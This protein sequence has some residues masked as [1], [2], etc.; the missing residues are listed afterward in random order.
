MRIL[1]ADED[2]YTRGFML[3]LLTKWGYESVVAADGD[4]AWLAL[5]RKNH[6]YL[7]ILNANL[8]C[9]SGVELARKVREAPDA[10]EYHI[11]LLTA[12]PQRQQALKAVASGDA[13]D[14]IAR[15]ADA[16]ELRIRVEMGRRLLDMKTSLRDRTNL[17]ALTGCMTH[18]SVVTELRGELNRS[19]RSGGVVAVI[20][21]DLDLFK[22]V[23]G[24]YGQ[25]AGD[26]VLAEAA[27]RITA[28]ARPYD[29][30]GRYGADEFLVVMPGCPLG[31]AHSRARRLR[32]Q[33][34]DSNTG[35][36]NR[37]VPVT[38]SVGVAA[39]D[40]APD[41]DA[42]SLLRAAEA[43]LATAKAAGG[44]RVQVAQSDDFLTAAPRA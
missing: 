13:Q 40:L 3:D 16:N 21:A 29:S 37:R 4:E 23:N 28:T 24:L 44:N 33:F 14:F 15:P 38:I 11:I 12:P 25:V 8:P 31:S 27:K 36:T 35:T 19:K 34:D 42:E 5:N 7:A 17:D 32:K 2:P 22:H 20:L 41:A 6:P 9:T 10:D 1:I 18:N 26:E 30:I 43:A 39:T